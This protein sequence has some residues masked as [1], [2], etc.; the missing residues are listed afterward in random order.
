MINWSTDEKKFKKNDP[1]GYR[2]W[3]LTQLINYGLDGEKLDKQEV[4]KAWPK[5]KDRLDPNT[6]AYFNYLLW[7]KRPASTDIKT[8][9]WHLS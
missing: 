6:L 8:D 2:L 5:I 9:F 7:G 1:K 3:R 4:K